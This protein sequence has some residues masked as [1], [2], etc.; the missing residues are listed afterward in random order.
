MSAEV[1]KRENCHSNAAAYL[2]TFVRTQGE[3]GC[4]VDPFH[5]CPYSCFSSNSLVICTL[6]IDF[7]LIFHFPH[8]RGSGS[9]LTTNS[10]LVDPANQ[11]R[12][13]VQ[14][15]GKRNKRC[16]ISLKKENKSRNLFC[17]TRLSFVH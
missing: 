5:I 7:T 10:Q 15:V 6:F 11:Y 1:L 17:T 9:L 13:P 16:G 14:A 4:G 3:A 12:R 2:H 8:L